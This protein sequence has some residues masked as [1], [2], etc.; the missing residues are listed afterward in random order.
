MYSCVWHTCPL[1]DIDSTL[2][3]DTT[4]HYLFSAWGLRNRSPTVRTF[5]ILHMIHD[6]LRR[7]SELAERCSCA[8]H[9]PVQS[10]TRGAPG[11][12][13]PGCGGVID[14]RRLHCNRKSVLWG[15]ILCCSHTRAGAAFSRCMPLTVRND[16]TRGFCLAV[17]QPIHSCGSACCRSFPLPASAN[18]RSLSEPCCNQP[19]PHQSAKFQS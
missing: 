10:C 9:D 8:W 2:I 12:R 3:F 14:R 17:F 19:P 15:S 16:L 1:A 6:N 18:H 5:G 11:C 7:G 4:A 13:E